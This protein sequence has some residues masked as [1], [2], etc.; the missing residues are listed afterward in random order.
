MAVIVPAEERL[1]RFQENEIPMSIPQIPVP[2]GSS[3][4]DIRKEL[5]PHYGVSPLL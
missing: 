2:S 5:E 1:T 4:E 3:D